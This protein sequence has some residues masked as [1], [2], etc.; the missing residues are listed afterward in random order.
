MD[1][2][3]TPGWIGVCDLFD[4]VT[5][6]P[7]DWG[8]PGTF[9]PGLESPVKLK[10][11]SMPADD[12]LRFNDDQCFFPSTPETGKDDPEDTISVMERRPFYRAFHDSKLVTKSYVF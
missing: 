3:C 8:T 2:G 11:L 10:S 9:W 7:A 12:C 5:D 6:F 4:K 1:F